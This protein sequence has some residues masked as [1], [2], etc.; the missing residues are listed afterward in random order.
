M[1]RTTLSLSLALAALT[2]SFATL[3]GC[4]TSEVGVT[5]TLGTYSTNVDATPEKATKAT[6]K[7]LEQ[8]KFL[9]IVANSTKIDG[10]VTAKTAQ[11]DDV[12]VNIEQS[13]DSVSKVSVRIGGTG[14]ASGSMKII[15]KIK[16][17]LH[18]F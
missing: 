17:N 6:Q 10:H 13:G 2:V 8:M 14:D 16:S 3:N 15:D 12:V 4:K 1:K 11:N 5:S 9:D 7:A 18:W